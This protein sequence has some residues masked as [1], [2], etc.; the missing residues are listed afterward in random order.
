MTQSAQRTAPVD[1]TDHIRQG[2]NEIAL[3]HLGDLTDCTF[4]L[5]ASE[6]RPMM[7][8]NPASDEIVQGEHME[9]D[10]EYADL[11][12]YLAQQE[13]DLEKERRDALDEVGEETGEASAMSA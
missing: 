12:K 13:Y 8:N 2:I 3:I 7:T 9:V 10:D 1:L 11:D 6:G 5:V 4:V